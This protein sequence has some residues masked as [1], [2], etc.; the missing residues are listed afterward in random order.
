M[1]TYSQTGQIN[2]TETSRLWS[3]HS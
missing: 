2:V 3:C 1:V